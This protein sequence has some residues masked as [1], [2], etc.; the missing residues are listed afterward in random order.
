M[1]NWRRDAAKIRS[2]DGYATCSGRAGRFQKL[3]EL[4]EIIVE[5]NDLRE[6]RFLRLGS[7][8]WRTNLNPRRRDTAVTARRRRLNHS[9]P[10]TDPDPYFKEQAP[11][12]L[13]YSIIPSL[14]GN[15]SVKNLI[16]F[17]PP[18]F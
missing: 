1:A 15:T 13:T 16:I 9:Q 3:A 2:R 6:F 18:F 10:P 11:G 12:R 17:L 7:G 14:N 5:I 8:A 4:S